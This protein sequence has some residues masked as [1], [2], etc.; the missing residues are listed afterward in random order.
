MNYRGLR[1]Q[2]LL[3]YNDDGS[4][5]CRH[6]IGLGE[7]AGEWQ[8][9]TQTLTR[10]TV[11]DEPGIFPNLP[12]AAG[13]AEVNALL[14]KHTVEDLKRFP[15]AGWK[16]VEWFKADLLNGIPLDVIKSFEDLAYFD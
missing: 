11:E 9:T 14:E 2:W 15:A 3:I 5:D 6:R 4:I 7:L 10:E 8:T 12:I 13:C 16:P 1:F